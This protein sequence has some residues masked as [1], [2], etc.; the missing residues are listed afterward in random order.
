MYNQYLRMKGRIYKTA[1]NFAVAGVRYYG[2]RGRDPASAEMS[3]ATRKYHCAAILYKIA[4]DDCEVYLLVTERDNG[5]EED[6]RHILTCQRTLAVILNHL[7]KE[8]T[9]SETRA[10]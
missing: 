8:S 1:H 10:S 5:M 6:L 9:A 7:D 2:A 3:E 4:L